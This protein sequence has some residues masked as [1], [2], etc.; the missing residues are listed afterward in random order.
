MRSLSDRATDTQTLTPGSEVSGTRPAVRVPTLA[1][2][3][4]LGRYRLL[5]LVGAGGVGEVYV[6]HDTQ[7]DRP[8]AI[9][10][11][12][13]EMATPAGRVQLAREA[14]INARLEHPNV[15][16]VYDLLNID[17]TD[18]LVSEYVE[19]TSLAETASASDI[20]RQ[21]TLALEICR[22]L[23]FAHDAGVVHL[24]L[25]A[26]N[27]LVGRDGVAKIADF[28]IAQ[29][30]GSGER[31]E[32]SG[33]TIRGTFRS[34]SP[35]QTL[36]SAADARSDL[37]SFGT[38]LYELFSGVSPFHVRGHAAETI[39]R[40]REQHP[41]PLREV[42]A[43]VPALLSELVQRLH[44]KDP[45]E[46]PESAR[47]V[48]AVLAELVE[49][50]AR[51]AAPSP[52][53]PPTER[54]LL[55]VLTCELSIEAPGSSIEQSAEYL[56][57]L[58]RFHQLVALV[59]ER[60]EAHVLN[61][62]GERAVLC[63]GYPRAHD[64][65]CERAARLV[66]E[67]RRE[68][69]RDPSA[70]SAPLRAGLDVGDTLLSGQL[71]A[72]PCLPASAALCAAAGP[73]EVLVSSRAQ[74]ILRRF[75]DFA[76]RVELS[77][78]APHGSVRS[79]PHHELLEQGS[80]RELEISLPPGSASH[81]IGREHELGVLAEAWH[82]CR[83][84]CFKALIVLAPAGVGKS[85][86]LATFGDRV[87]ESGAEVVRLRARPEDQYLPF[88]P[89]AELLARN[90]EEPEAATGGRHR[91]DE[92]SDN[93]R[94]RILDAGLAPL[95]GPALDQPLLLILEDAHWLDHSSWALLR[96]LVQRRRV[97]P[98]LLLLS[99]RPECLPEVS[100]V[101]PVQTLS[102]SRLRS[103]E[104]FELIQNVPGGRQL[105][106]HLAL[107]IVEAA[108]GLPL[109]LEELT[110][111]VVERVR[112]GGSAPRLLEVPS[113]LTESLD[114]RLETL[115]SARD[116]LDLLAALGRESVPS[117]LQKLSGLE[118]RELAAQLARLSNAGLVFEEGVGAKRTLLFRH[119]LVGD[120]IYERLPLERR[121]EL[122]RRIAC[123][124]QSSFTDWLH[125]RPDLFAVHF[126]RSGQAFEAAL[127]FVR[128]GE[129]A[130]R[131]SCHFEACAHFRRAQGLLPRCD[132]TEEQRAEWNQ[133][134]V[135]LLCPSLQAGEAASVPPPGAVSELA[136]SQP[137]AARAL[138]E[139]WANLSYACFRHDAAGASE[140]LAHLSRLP[141]TPARDALLAMA[142]GA[143]EFYRGE[144]ERAERSLLV[145]ERLASHAGARE[146]LSECS[147]DVLVHVPCYLS[148]LHAL[149]EESALA[150]ERRRQAEAIPRSFVVARGLGILFGTALGILQ[151]E[152][153]S[154]SGLLRQ[155]QR[156]Q[157]LTR[158]AA[159]VRH[160]LFH[161]V[162]EI[163]GGRLE[164]ARGAMD[165]G[166]IRMR[167]GLELYEETGAQLSLVQYAGFV[168]EAHLE[169]GRLAEARE[170]IERVRPLAAHPYARFC[171]PDFLR[172]EGQ[173]FWAEGR[174]HEAERLLVLAQESAASG[175]AGS[176]P[177]LYCRRIEAA[178]YALGEP[179]AAG[180]ARVASAS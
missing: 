118:P 119:H 69:L 75:F 20:D 8:V 143:I 10:R 29:R 101:L 14:R 130:S 134:I 74:R 154:S 103:E 48:E 87:A 18:F 115:G 137:T 177:R 17:G 65:N 178:R 110:L 39:R 28:G 173:L 174:P 71:A 172:L 106:H 34:M 85:R 127:L 91:G 84:G 170:L 51:R 151:R 62:F 68:W 160:P 171:R 135:R 104:A 149:R 180:A 125:E 1:A 128:A 131:R 113:S 70:S 146:G 102:V 21:L 99:G 122:H 47:E 124:V 31:L 26:E 23:A 16:R 45:S 52:A 167:R 2:G 38:L 98:F 55:S 168:A 144:F 100:A 164:L 33:V 142:T 15:V 82:A 72:G 30:I 107:Q 92:L 86:L 126:E 157:E 145:G 46:R 7:L 95:L 3:Q 153:E 120:A 129:R 59:A 73:F 162:A 163:A 88:A 6:G 49:R 43:E 169:S 9:K 141:A 89:F 109:L 155:Q 11:L 97:R 41:P 42:R 54:R 27:I 147:Q 161:A 138:A 111:S 105:S 140:V 80:A 179:P 83:G 36:A 166:L 5:E 58:A 76:P 108:D 112:Q 24:D 116:T 159:Q 32:S 93:Y 156:V 90:D 81:L 176:E 61:A 123:V 158:A 63:L 67:L 114:R 175:G 121:E 78:P 53:G 40:I 66:L 94:Q 44:R 139:H 22:G 35:E 117:I 37:F 150:A 50:R 12:R 4:Q 60:R 25:K 96:S 56:R 152:H 132:L 165:A 77:C 133:H 79:I 19:G 148:V 13:A 64:N 136:P 57:T